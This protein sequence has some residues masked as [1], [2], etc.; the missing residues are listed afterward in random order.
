MAIEAADI[1]TVGPGSWFTS[2]MP[3]LVMPEIADAVAASSATP[4]PVLN[5]VEQQE[6]TGEFPPAE[7]VA[8]LKCHALQVALDHVIAASTHIRARAGRHDVVSACASW[9]SEVTFDDVSATGDRHDPGKLAR[10]FDTV[11]VR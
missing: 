2:V 5:L 3:H 11:L 9:G 4:V 8:A 10:V 1:A 7:H 6:E